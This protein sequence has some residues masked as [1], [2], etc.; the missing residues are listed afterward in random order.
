[1]LKA[2]YTISLW[3]YVRVSCICKNNTAKHLKYSQQV[4]GLTLRVNPW[5]WNPAAASYQ[6][7]NTC[8]FRIALCSSER[9]N[10]DETGLTDIAV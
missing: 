1:M 7:I 6:T 8:G 10:S 3:I 9:T 4:L 2:E 5:L